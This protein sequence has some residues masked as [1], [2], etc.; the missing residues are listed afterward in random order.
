MSFEHPWVLAL[1]IAPVVFLLT[2]WRR[3]PSRAGLL[4]KTVAF[5]A[6]VLALAGPSIEPRWQP[7]YW[8][9]LRQA[10]L[11]LTFSALPN[12]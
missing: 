11:P 7:S 3:T 10:F 4:L 5:L 9:I 1:L 8:W 12:W 6:V 2:E